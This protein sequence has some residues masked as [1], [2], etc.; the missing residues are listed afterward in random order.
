MLVVDLPATDDCIGEATDETVSIGKIFPSLSDGKIIGDSHGDTV[1]DAV[2][3]ASILGVDV[4]VV[5]RAVGE[6]DL[7]T[8][9]VKVVP[10]RGPCIG[11]QRGETCAD[12]FF[13]LEG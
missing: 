1:G 11:S 3:G 4:G 10:V 13:R 9:T 7:R 6:V 8:G 12:T 2:D 5:L